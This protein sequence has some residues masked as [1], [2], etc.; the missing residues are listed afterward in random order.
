MISGHKSEF[1]ARGDLAVISNKILH[2]ATQ[3]SS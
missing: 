1:Y 3:K 2:C